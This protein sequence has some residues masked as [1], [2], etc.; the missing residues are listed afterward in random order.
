MIKK[1][2]FRLAACTAALI[3]TGAAVSACGEPVPET[4]RITEREAE[5]SS[6]ETFSVEE[7]RSTDGEGTTASEKEETPAETPTEET[8][9][10][11]SGTEIPPE[12]GPEA[13]ETIRFFGKKTD[14]AAAEVNRLTLED[15]ASGLYDLLAYQAPKRAEVL[16]QI[17][18]YELPEAALYGGKLLSEKKKTAILKNRDLDT[19]REDPDG[20][21]F[22]R[23]A[24]LTENTDLRAFP[25]GKKLAAG[26]DDAGPD[27]LQETMLPLGAGVIL[28]HTSAD[29][30]WF[31]VQAEYYAGWI[32]GSCA[33]FCTEEEFRNYLETD[34]FIVALK[35]DVEVH[36]K[37]LRLGA[38]LPYAYQ[39]AHLFVVDFPVRDE[40]SGEFRTVPSFLTKSDR[41][42][43]GYCTPSFSA[44]MDAALALEGRPYGWGDENN[45]YDC[46]SA[47]GGIY[48]TMG[49]LLP[50]NT[51]AMAH[52]G[53]S[54]ADVRT[55][56]AEEKLRFIEERPGALLLM[57]GHVMLYLKKVGNEHLVFNETTGYN[58][59][60]GEL[61]PVMSAV[62]SVLEDLYFSDGNSFV[63][64]ITDV[65]DP[66]EGAYR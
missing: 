2:L 63:S 17:E 26:E 1:L 49:I 56:S 58:T 3:I 16:Q 64:L 4:A 25:A 28:L 36:G 9:T 20:T 39:T 5:A 35:P 11:E 55:F 30:N 50:R 47:V 31:F 40:A 22:I 6:Q 43:D 21:A 44:V 48:R 54:V 33:A 37:K 51:S 12:S 66:L 34:R 27:L 61:V 32:P 10:E 14:A 8:A 19:L 42:S 53:G 13:D 65:I 15:T 29:G 57:K 18:K 46:S 24:I 52:F 38:V 41:I 23:Y 62:T 59:A 7:S 60:E 45:D